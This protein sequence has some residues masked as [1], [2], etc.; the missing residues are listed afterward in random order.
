MVTAAYDRGTSRAQR[1]PA[2]AGSFV[3][4]KPKSLPNASNHSGRQ[5]RTLDSGGA[6]YV[7][8]P[9]AVTENTPIKEP[10]APNQDKVGNTAPKQAIAERR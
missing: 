2:K 6:G 4:P 9:A 8:A 10:H 3:D 1:T 7:V 5:K